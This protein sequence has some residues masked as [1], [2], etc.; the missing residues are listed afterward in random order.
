MIISCW[1]LKKLDDQALCTSWRMCTAP[2]TGC[3]FQQ[4]WNWIKSSLEIQPQVCRK[5]ETK[6]VKQYDGIQVNKIMWETLRIIT[7]FLQVFK[8]IYLISQL[9]TF[10]YWP[11]KCW[12]C[13][14]YDNDCLYVNGAVFIKIRVFIF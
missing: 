8:K 11:Y 5:Y 4:N 9:R 2:R 3:F 10:E 1:H 12:F 6:S 7:Q 13:F 14:S